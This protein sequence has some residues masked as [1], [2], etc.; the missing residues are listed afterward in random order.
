MSRFTR[1]RV[2]DAAGAVVAAALV[3][4]CGGDSQARTMEGGE[5]IAMRPPAA[6]VKTV[7]L[8]ETVTPV[9]P[10]TTRTPVV[11]SYDEAFTAFRKGNYEEARTLFESYVRSN[12]A[13]AQ[14]Q[15][16]L[17]LSA[18]KT[19]DH[20]R[21]NTAL[22]RAVELN[23]ESLKARTNLARVLLERNKPGEALAHIDKAA[24]LSPDS[25]EVWRVMGNTKAQLGKA[26]EALDAYRKAIMI[27]EKDA[28]SMNN[29]GLLL[30]QIDRPIDAL[31]PLARA[32][33]L[34][35]NSAMFLNNLGVALEQSG[36]LGG[37][38]DVF[39][40]ALEVD[41]THVKA[42]LSLERVIATVGST[43]VEPTDL[44][45]FARLFEDEIRRWKEPNPIDK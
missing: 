7:A 28:W 11:A 9:A 6:A 32:V 30:I 5:Q 24:E 14:G 21:A 34:A 22:T 37:A 44:K 1:N 42:K 23:G 20:E 12:D 17:G 33:E 41:S 40:R 25:H 13:D 35:P 15:Y 45:Q 43:E 8:P 19:G 4:A 29:Y 18:W 39:T 3:S 26:D 38:R 10:V 36:D 2:I 31:P 27:D 16:M